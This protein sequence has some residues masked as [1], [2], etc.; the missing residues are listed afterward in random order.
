M[1]IFRRFVSSIVMVISWFLIVVAC[2]N[3]DWSTFGDI[4]GNFGFVAFI[5]ELNNFLVSISSG[6]VLFTLSFLGITLDR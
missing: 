5:N 3:Y 4:F 6:L 1:L 2:V